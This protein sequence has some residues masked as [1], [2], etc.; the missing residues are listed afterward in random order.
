M[1]AVEYW[2]KPIHRLVDEFQVQIHPQ[3]LDSSMMAL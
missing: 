2:C 1:R 3:A